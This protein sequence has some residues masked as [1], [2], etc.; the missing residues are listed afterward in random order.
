MPHTIPFTHHSQ[1]LQGYEGGECG[2]GDAGDGVVVQIPSQ[3]EATHEHAAKEKNCMTSMLTHGAMV[4]CIS[5][6]PQA[7]TSGG[8]QAGGRQPHK[9]CQ[10]S[11][12]P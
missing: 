10:T 1:I 4:G 3:T 12:E 2:A 5:V 7:Q 9:K 6:A 8:V 11:I